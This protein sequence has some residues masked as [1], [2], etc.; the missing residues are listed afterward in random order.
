[1]GG[2]EPSHDTHRPCGDDGLLSRRGFIVV[3]YSSRKRELKTRPIYECRCD[4][5]LKTKAEE[6]T[7][8]AYTGWLVELEHLKIKTTLIDEMFASVMG[9]YVF[10][11]EMMG[12]PSKLSVIRKAAAFARARPTLL[13]SWAETAARR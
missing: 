8:L 5:R 9:E 2:M 4:E 12:A 11:L 7:R 6:S 1:M 3:Y 10:F 13:V